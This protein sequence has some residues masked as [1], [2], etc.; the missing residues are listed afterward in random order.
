MIGYVYNP[1]GTLPTPIDTALKAAA[2][3]GNVL[4]QLGFGI[5]ADILGRKEVQSS[6]LWLTIDVRYGIDHHDLCYALSF[7]FRRRPSA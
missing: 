3:C 6:H 7:S 2:P 5:L 1:K 4:G